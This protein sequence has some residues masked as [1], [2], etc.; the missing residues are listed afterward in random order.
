VN[1]KVALAQSPDLAELA[2][3]LT[4]EAGRRCK[5]DS[6]ILLRK[7]SPL[8]RANGDLYD[9]NIVEEMQRRHV[10]H[11]NWAPGVDG[12]HVDEDGDSLP[13]PPD[14]RCYLERM[15]TCAGVLIERKAGA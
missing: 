10:L 14:G 13:S 15:L 6:F 9:E 11:L 1:A 8:G 7:S 3:K 12:K 5:V 2:R 4:A